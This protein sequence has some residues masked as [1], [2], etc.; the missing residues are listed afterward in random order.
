MNSETKMKCT[1]EKKAKCRSKNK[2]CNPVTGRCIKVGGSAYKKVFPKGH[3]GSTGKT[4]K[5]T[6]T[7]L[8]PPKKRAKCMSK[9]KVCNPVTG[10]CIK[11]G[12]KIYKSI[13]PEGHNVG[14]IGATKA[15]TDSARLDVATTA[16][17]I[18]ANKG[19]FNIVSGFMGTKACASVS[20]WHRLLPIEEGKRLGLK[21]HKGVV[22]KTTLERIN[23]RFAHMYKSKKGY[24]C[25]SEY[26]PAQIKKKLALLHRIKTDRTFNSAMS[27]FWRKDRVFVL[28]V[29]K[30]PR[31]N[32]AFVNSDE[33]FK[34]DKEV[35]IAAVS[36]DDFGYLLKY[37]SANLRD[38]KEVVLAAVTH[39]ITKGGKS[40]KSN[41]LM[42]YN[43]IQNPLRFASKRLRDDKDV[44]MTAIKSESRFSYNEPSLYFASPRLRHDKDVLLA[45][46]RAIR[47]NVYK[48]KDNYI[49]RALHIL[50]GTWA[51]KGILS[52][53]DV[54]KAIRENVDIEKGTKYFHPE[55]LPPSDGFL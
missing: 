22:S 17:D 4:V 12:G 25:F 32:G 5:K 1:S 36:R 46:I 48:F 42:Q 21:L 14:A 50:S 26:T 15:A 23:R 43:D 34:S 47:T 33:K 45:G 38:D 29:L 20:P 28:A 53:Y 18:A 40:N 55:E 9:G 24:G 51:G 13:F 19:L 10:R 52:D 31:P 41:Y 3:N 16:V 39:K 7:N 49:V 6:P 27:K 44:I 30:H 54:R 35:V 8:C 11:I 37:A 2:V